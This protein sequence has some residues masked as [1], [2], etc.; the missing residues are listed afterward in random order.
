MKW[1]VFLFVTLFLIIS[2]F[3]NKEVHAQSNKELKELVT[4]IAVEENVPPEILKAIAYIETGFQQFDANGHPIIS[5]DGGIGIMQVTPDNIDIEVNRERLKTDTEYNVRI[6]A[7]VLKE[8]KNL[9]YLPVINEGSSKVLEDWYFAVMA[10]NGLSQRNDPN[11]YPKTAYAERVYDRISG[12]ALIEY[13]E[14][15]FLFPRF[16]LRYEDNS[17]LIYF[18]EEPRSYGTNNQTVSRQMYEIGDTV[19]IDGKDGG[20]NFREG[21][22]SE[23]GVKVQPNTEWTIQG[24]PVEDNNIANH[25][26]FYQVSNGE[27]EGYIAS[28]Y[29][30]PAPIEYKVFSDMEDT[31][32]KEINYLVRLGIINGYPDGTFRPKDTILRT[33]AVTMILREMGID[34]DAITAPDPGFED[35]GPEFDSYKYV[36]KAVDMGFISGKDNGRIFDPSGEL[37]RAQMA[38]IMVE[39][40]DLEGTTDQQFLDV[41]KPT[42][43]DNGHWAYEYINTLAAN[44]ITTGYPNGYFAPQA[45]IKREHFAL[46]LYRYLTEI[47][48]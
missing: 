47:E 30:A 40:Y 14:P 23:E 42:M 26:V 25:Y 45:T 16:D 21:S 28:A 24:A 32:A 8:K 3:M 11:L 35:F 46:F 44:E 5:A 34:K 1:R 48:A 43:N 36:S 15:Y 10:Y 9:S 13:S 38:K 20:A 39:A 18:P 17:E 4:N 12:S 6:A 7:Q 41:K 31:Y 29:L 27:K 19:Y 22:L 2:P 37:Q 33:Q